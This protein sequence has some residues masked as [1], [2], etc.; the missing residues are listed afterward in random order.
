MLTFLLHTLFSHD[1]SQNSRATVE[2][3]S[4]GDVSVENENKLWAWCHRCRRS[5]RCQDERKKNNSH[6]NWGRVEFMISQEVCWRETTTKKKSSND[7][8]VGNEQFMNG[9]E[10]GV[11]RKT[12]ALVKLKGTA[13]KRQRLAWDIRERV[14]WKQIYSSD[15]IW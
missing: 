3:E 1:F 11:R 5:R 12:W 6:M 7:V 15:E 14:T 13:K 9:N 10:A 8:I 2:N 4:L